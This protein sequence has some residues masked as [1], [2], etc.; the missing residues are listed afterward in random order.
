M[1]VL[2]SWLREFTP[3]G[4]DVEGLADT[5]SDLGMAVE[6][7]ERLGADLA[8]IVVA[9]VLA[10]RRH[11]NA[12][13]IGLVDVD[14]GDGEAL[15]ICCG[16][17][18]MH[19]GDLVPLA[20]VG[21]TMPDGRRI[22]RAKLR[23]EWSNGMLCSARE[24]Q[25]GDDHAGILILAPTAQPGQDVGRALGLRDDVVFDLDL[26]GNRPEALSM[27]GVAR[28]LAARLR[29]PFTLPEPPL[30][31]ASG[32][33]TAADAVR[34]EI[35]APDLCGRFGA[36]VLRDVVIGPS[37]TWLANRL[38]AVGMRPINNVVDVSNYVMFE[39]G[40]PSHTF[41]LAKVAGAA[42]RVRWARAGERLVTLDGQE[43][44]LVERDGVIAD[45]DDEAVSLA[46]VMGGRSTEISEATRDVLVEMAWWDPMAIART[47]RRL[48]LRSD[49]A[50]RFERGTDP[51]VVEL[52]MRRFAELLAE[53]SP[54]ALLP[55]MVDE[56]GDWPEPA[57]IRVRTS[58]VN[59][60]LGLGLD[61]ET[62]RGLLEP[63]GFRFEP[64][65]PDTAE[66][67]PA[68]VAAAGASSA[69]AV[70]GASTAPVAGDG[71][72]Q[73]VTVPSYRPD[74]TLEID[75][76]EEVARQY[77]YGR[78]PVSLPSSPH[79]GGLTPRQRDRR[80]LRAAL[81]GFGLTEAMP[82]PFLAPDD[83]GRA[84]LD[85]DAVSV[86]N[87]LDAKESVLRTSLRPGLLKTIAYN[88]S[89]RQSGAELF[90]M[91]HVYLPADRTAELPDEREHLG[92]ALAGREA[93]A[94]VVGWGAVRDALVL[95][96]TALVADDPPGLHPTRTARVE[97]AGTPVG[98]VGEVDPAVAAAFDVAE[99]VAWMEIDLTTLLELPHGECAY[100]PISRY[101]SSDIDLAFVVPEAVPA[102][103]VEA[104]LRGAA[105]ELLAD[106]RLFDV[107]RGGPVGAGQ[108][109]LAFRLRLQAADRTLTDAEVGTVRARCIELVE[110]E[111]GAALRS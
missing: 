17:F 2:L 55:G 70:G 61:G 18:N 87:P 63:I 88:A 92:V 23:G 75:V 71:S 34:V 94:A 107:Y 36:R 106:L 68:A 80:R 50:T 5:L 83:L 73:W 53:S 109:S 15:Q 4:D 57:R 48:N 62:I 39:L 69:P 45:G 20:T 44:T 103:A 30:V 67:Q 89:H 90:E 76:V 27:A 58:R 99:R 74:T 56:R 22:E 101:P 9:R 98:W 31:E 42:L 59:Q 97:V 72:V 13:R 29:L 24:L 105:G 37:P 54:V 49:A 46:G 12:E 110:A 1:K 16:A 41:D 84:G 7:V 95:A 25:L 10:T 19:A 52:A 81:V 26:T 82:L 65:P 14:A 77:G 11:P 47:S 64:A 6:G 104:T 91:G 78:I 28:D 38:L 85:A 111:H 8:G 102:G 60:L 51:L 96:G 66:P 93:P 40:Q 3:L 21:T 33:G 100:R 79:T 32:R 43:R 86:A 108:R 35:L